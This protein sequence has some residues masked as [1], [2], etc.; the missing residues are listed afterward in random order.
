MGIYY[1]RRKEKRLRITQ[2]LAPAA[3]AAAAAPVPDDLLVSEI[4]ARLPVKTLT[5]CKSVCRSWR[6]ALE[7]PSFVRRHLELSRTRTPPSALVIP[8]NGGDFLSRCISFHR[9]RSPEHTATDAAAAA[10]TAELM[11][12][13]ACPEEIGCGFVPS[14]CDG[15]VAV[16]GTRGHIFVCNPATRKLCFW[17]AAAI[18][19]DPWRD[20]YVVCRY[21]DLST[22]PFF[23]EATGRETSYWRLGHEIFTLG[24]GGGDSWVET[25]PPP[26]PGRHWPI[27]ELGAICVRGDFYWLSYTA[28]GAAGDGEA[29]MALL[30]FGLRDAK[31][32]VVRRP[33]GCTCRRRTPSSSDDGYFYFTDRVVDLSGKVC[34]V[35]APLAADFLELWQLADHDQE[36]LPRCRINLLDRG[37]VIRKEGFVPVYHHGED[38]LLVLDDEQLYRY[39]ERARAIEEVANLERELEEYER[40]DGTDTLEYKHYVVP[41]VESLVSI[42]SSNY[43]IK[44]PIETLLMYSN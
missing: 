39:N 27:G 3:S 31:F 43:I 35:H 6:A 11:L 2:S 5:R 7:D 24:G 22:E 17:P 29:E 8:H 16:A 1:G 19:Y 32:D 20:R 15:L 13:A 41:Y 18:G 9:L 30:R 12:E 44:E 21:F 42:C 40:Q 26:P 25:D 37:I 14:H 33:R 10:A 34:Y 23:D 4:L 36:W 28:A 38:M